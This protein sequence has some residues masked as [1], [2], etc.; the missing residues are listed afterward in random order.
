MNFAIVGY[1]YSR[2]NILLDPSIP[3]EDLDSKIHT[4]VAAYVRSIALFGQAGKIDAVVPFAAGDWRGRLDGQ[5]TTRVIDGFG[6]PRI[7]FSW[8]SFG[9]PSLSRAEFRDYRQG[10]IVG[11]SIQVSV[12]IGQYDNTKRINLS[13]NRWTFKPQL[14]VSR[15]VGPWV[16]EAY[17]NAWFFTTNSDFFNGNTLT[18]QPLFAGKVHLIRL[19]PKGF[20]VA[21][22][23]GYGIGGRT[24]INGER[25][26][27]H[28]SSFRF[29]ATV[30]VPLARQ[31]T[32]K[33]VLASGARVER[34]PDF[35]AVA[36]TYQFR[37]GGR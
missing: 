6:D 19:L 14:G 25:R 29:G 5:D 10:T 2:G 4:M 21:V 3:I 31:H 36:V 13:V 32:L 35:D 24:S 26:E 34:G 33:F 20:W 22:D 28:I 8:N 1:G 9:S 17:A 15:A 30:A 16:V 27:T 18:Q 7:R 11:A 12:P 37:W 23:G